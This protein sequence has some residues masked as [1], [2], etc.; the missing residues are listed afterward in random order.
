MRCE[1]KRVE[2]MIDQ[3]RALIENGEVGALDPEWLAGVIDE[4]F[5][6]RSV[7]LA[8][9]SSQ[10]FDRYATG[11][12]PA[13]VADTMAS[14]MM[15]LK[16]G[17]GEREGAMLMTRLA[18]HGSLCS[19]YNLAIAKFRGQGTPMD[20][21]GGNALLKRVIEADTTA[22]P[23]LMGVAMANL[24]ESMR[25]GR[26]CQKDVARAI[27][28]LEEAAAM[29]SAVAA[30]NAALYFNGKHDDVE[31]SMDL[32]K[33]AKLYA[34]AAAAGMVEARTNL[35]V[36]H[37]GGLIKEADPRRGVA[38]L[39]ESMADGDATA[40]E[41]LETL[42]GMTAELE[43][44]A[45]R[46]SE[47]GA[48]QQR[49]NSLDLAM[50][51]A[52][53]DEAQRRMSEQ[54]KSSHFQIEDCKSFEE[55]WSVLRR[56]VDAGQ[57]QE[58][59]LNGFDASLAMPAAIA[60]WLRVRRPDLLLKDE[61][62]IAL[63]GAEKM[64]FLSLF[65]M[66][67]SLCGAAHIRLSIDVVGPDA[68]GLMSQWG[69]AEVSLEADMVGSYAATGE[70]L[71]G[72]DLAVAFHPGFEEHCDGWLVYDDGLDLISEAGVEIMCASYAPE[73]FAMDA[74]FAAACGMKATD[75]VENPLR[76]GRGV[77]EPGTD[78]WAC[79]GLWRLTA[80]DR[81]VEVNERGRRLR[82]LESAANMGAGFI[83]ADMAAGVNHGDLRKL[84]RRV[85]LRDDEGVYGEYFVLIRG[86]AVKTSTGEMVRLVGDE[87]GGS[88]GTSVPRDLMVCIPAD[89]AKWA[90]KAVWADGV[91]RRKLQPWLEGGRDVVSS[92][93]AMVGGASRV[94]DD[95]LVKLF[96][97]RPGS[98]EFLD[99]RRILGAR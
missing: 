47:R 12:L 24:A 38:L 87:L 70:R 36:L 72:L 14:W 53:V 21:A 27:S 77:N 69:L 5:G 34:Q 68:I 16:D 76:Y 55:L 64:E 32:E 49:F 52:V 74:E 84:G 3:V 20:A 86:F 2:Q 59:G 4:T 23:G 58:A 60:W 80:G 51:I 19:M 39:R 97:M 44:R 29:G 7:D 15:G 30:Y 45:A 83:K 9:L 66:V 33:A 28:M 90:D 75:C 78:T 71:K 54:L 42:L 41:A 31:V 13:V 62:R 43:E 81:Y 17:S 88:V 6:N 94:P 40:K 82:E 57:L 26:G 37:L 48:G 35:G 85:L 10:T 50:K 93:H 67:P 99:V 56:A 73:E 79:W 18:A 96:N 91:W 1:S 89:S 8:D 65:G 22:Y 46:G 25:D 98:R 11:E 63:L 95:V 92:V 61:L